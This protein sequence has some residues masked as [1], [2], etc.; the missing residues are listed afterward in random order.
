MIDY[1]SVPRA[2]GNAFREIPNAYVFDKLDGTS[3]RSEWNRKRGWYKHGLRHTRNDVSNPLS[4]F[5]EIPKLFEARLAEPL[6]K[7]LH[8]ERWMKATVYYEYWGK[9]SLAGF[10]VVDDPKFVTLFDVLD[11]NGDF[12]SP[13]DFYNMFGVRPDLPTARF[14]GRVN[15]TRG[16]VDQVRRGEIEGITSEGVVA[17]GWDRKNNVIRAKAKTQAWIERVIA[18]HGEG[19]GHKLVES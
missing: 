1:P 5:A 4:F 14:L 18:K 15:W 3:A 19:E 2:V 12:L 7:I 16:Y 6:A 13:P 10:H 8:D 9:Q 11:T 17:K